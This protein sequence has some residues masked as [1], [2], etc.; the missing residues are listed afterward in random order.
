M[1]MNVHL[2]VRV[3]RLRTDHTAICEFSRH[4]SNPPSKASENVKFPG[5]TTGTIELTLTQKSGD[6]R[7]YF[8]NDTGAI[9]IG[10]ENGTCPD[11]AGIQNTPFSIVSSSKTSVKIKN[12]NP[13]DAEYRYQLNFVDD[14]G[15]SYIRDPRIKNGG[16]DNN[17]EKLI[18][19]VLTGV[20]ILTLAVLAAFYFGASRQ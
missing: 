2:D 12:P 11:K 18:V 13:Y 16:R 9:W 10:P 15:E 5:R 7:V 8:N 3:T 20:T 1:N 17:N 19:Y 4:G 14:F 6:P